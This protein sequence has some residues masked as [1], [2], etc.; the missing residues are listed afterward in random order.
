[1]NERLERAADKVEIAEVETRYEWAVD[2]GRVERL[3]DL[4]AENA[5][6]TLKRYDVDLDGR[7]AIV[8]WF[9]QYCTE[10]GW[11]NRRHYLT[12]MQIVLEGD[13]ARFRGYYLITYEAEGESRLGWGHYDDRLERRGDSWIIVEKHIYS[14]GPMWL[15]KGWAGAQLESSAEDWR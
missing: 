4:F 5:R 1:M 13:H 3:N 15:A 6:L 11:E 12:N 8:D 14:A 10:W 7:A 9:R 2:E